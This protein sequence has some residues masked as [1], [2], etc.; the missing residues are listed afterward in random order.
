M[1]MLFFHNTTFARLG[2]SLS[3]SDPANPS[4]TLLEKT[5]QYIASNESCQDLLNN[6]VYIVEE[7]EKFILYLVHK[8]SEEIS[9]YEISQLQRI[10]TARYSHLEKTI[11]A[12]ETCSPNQLG[13][14]V[15]I[16]DYSLLG[17]D[18]LT[19][20]KVRRII[21]GFT[22]YPK[23]KLGDLRKN[24]SHFTSQ[25]VVDSFLD[26]L[27]ADKIVL[28]ENLQ[29][30]PKNKNGNF[31]ELSDVA[32]KGTDSLISGSAKIWG[33]LSDNLKWRNG[34]LNGDKSV[35]EILKHRLKPLD[36]IF[37][38][39]K[40][41]LS[42]Y[43]IPGHWGHVAVWLGTKEELIESGVWDKNYFAPFRA[44]VESGKNIIEIRK[45]GMQFVSLESFTNL[46]EI[47]VT[48]MRNAQTDS[49]EILNNINDE[50]DATYDFSFN[51]QT[52]DKLTCSEMVAYGY[53]DI[54][55]P[56]M[57]TLLQVSLR[58]DDIG[59]LSLYKD[60]PEEFV[61]YIKGDENKLAEEQ[62]YDDW[63]LLF[64]EK[65]EKKLELTYQ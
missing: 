5:L 64:H 41:T 50:M 9:T 47:A 26:K 33:F 8:K 62:S 46:D 21:Y 48:R 18:A 54:H 27:N 32:V 14:A 42:N 24:Y 59:V 25:Q 1:A 16:Y 51:A 15:A 63:E 17:Q 34:W 28:P 4:K 23:Y 38:K 30:N 10:L 22:K 31:F 2:E 61:L 52:P 29:A 56:A 60:S 11:G 35:L 55:W 58:P 19:D 43:T 12:Y 65:T 13:E 20:R 37:E 6:H 44:A 7:S 36:L 57:K 45:K 40:Y 49:E 3:T 53:G 39:R